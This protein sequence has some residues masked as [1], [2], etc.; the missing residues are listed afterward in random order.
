MISCLKPKAFE[1][2]SLTTVATPHRGSSAADKVGEWVKAG[3]ITQLV[4]V[5]ASIGFDLRTGAFTQLTTDYMNETFNPKC[6]DDPS[7]KLASLSR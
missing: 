3:K 1:V 4:E 6:P 2:A 5:A 7:V